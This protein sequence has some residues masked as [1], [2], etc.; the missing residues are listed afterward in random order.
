[1]K[2]VN[3]EDGIRKDALKALPDMREWLKFNTPDAI[4]V[5]IPFDSAG[6]FD[7]MEYNITDKKFTKII[8]SKGKGNM[9]MKGLRENAGWFNK[10][11]TCEIDISD[12]KLFNN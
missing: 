2:K 6:C 10:A 3:I 5:R 12:D 8:Y 4:F 7:L 1:M 11:V 9:L